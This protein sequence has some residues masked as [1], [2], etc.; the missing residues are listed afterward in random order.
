MAEYV[1][2]KML[3]ALNLTYPAGA[4]ISKPIPADVQAAVDRLHQLLADGGKGSAE[5]VAL[6]ETVTYYEAQTGRKIFYEHIGLAT[7]ALTGR[8]AAGA[9]STQSVNQTVAL[10][11]FFGGKTAAMNTAANMATNPN[12]VSPEV[13]GNGLVPEDMYTIPSNGGTFM[14]KVKKYGPYVAG[15]A[16]ILGILYWAFGRRK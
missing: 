10:V 16:I 1:G 11:N 7:G 13:I 2:N 5:W 15:G 6:M 4:A 9:L 12:V 8:T 14:D 3:A